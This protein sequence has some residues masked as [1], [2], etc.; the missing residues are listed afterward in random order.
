VTKNFAAQKFVDA[1]GAKSTKQSSL[2][3][4]FWE[5]AIWFT[6]NINYIGKYIECL[7]DICCAKVHRCVGNQIPLSKQVVYIEGRGLRKI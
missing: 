7:P 6:N 2:S 4:C 3:L 5:N 1:Y